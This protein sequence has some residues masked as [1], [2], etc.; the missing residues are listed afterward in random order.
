MVFSERLSRSVAK[1]V[2]YRIIIL[3]ADFSVVYFL[4]RSTDIALGFVVVSNVYTTILY[5]LHERAWDRI[6]W[7]K[8]A[9]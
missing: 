3:I 1:A 8:V 4:T 2:S 9:K 5:F 6:H 7:G